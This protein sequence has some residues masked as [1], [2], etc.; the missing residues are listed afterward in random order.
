MTA[1]NSGADH[2][3][4]RDLV[5]EAADQ[6]LAERVRPTVANVRERI[7]R[8][9]TGTINAALREWWDQVAE[10]ITTIAGRPDIPA[11]IYEAAQGLWASALRETESLMA[12]ERQTLAEQRAAAEESVAAVRVELEKAQHQVTGLLQRVE[13]ADT[14]RLALERRLA[15]AN[16][17]IEASNTR[18]EELKKMLAERAA[19]H[20]AA[21]TN[22]RAHCEGL[23]RHLL[24]QIEEHRTA[25]D[26]AEKKL[27]AKE[28]ASRSREAQLQDEIRDARE[29]AGTL[30]GELA[31]FRTQIQELMQSL[32]V[33]HASRDALV[34]EVADAKAG[35]A[36]SNEDCAHLQISN[37]TLKTELALV[38]QKYQDLDESLRDSNTR[39]AAAEAEARALRGALDQGNPRK[40]RPRDRT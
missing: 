31:A 13:S 5:M 39:L 8:G 9:S 1:P 17:R 6:L 4:T 30:R 21:I 11:P 34:K 25:R 10:R 15:T 35:W 14:E 40:R 38:R 36:R 29:A 20:E 12:A 33:L 24:G 27:V 32:E 22:E 28:T 37:E 7:G 3:R 23:E 19:Q 16:A 26:H 18:V 2:R